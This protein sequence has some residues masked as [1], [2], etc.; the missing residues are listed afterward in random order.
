MERGEGLDFYISET[1]NSNNSAD[2]QRLVLVAD[3]KEEKEEWVT[4]LE[5]EINSNLFI[6][7]PKL[8]EDRA[9][10]AV[11]RAEDLY[12]HG[13]KPNQISRGLSKWYK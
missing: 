7:D 10:G 8:A 13:E 9:S 3:S 1:W 6:G 5:K 4:V 2:L 11:S 12:D